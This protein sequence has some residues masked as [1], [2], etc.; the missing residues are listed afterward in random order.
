LNAPL[1]KYLK[2][3]LDRAGF[4]GLSMS[5]TPL[6]TRII[7]N[8]TRPGL[9]IGKGGKTI[10]TITKT[11]EETYKIPNPQIEINEIQNPE[12]DAKAMVDRVVSLL[13]RG[14]SWR[15]VTYKT[16]EDIIRA[17]AQG[18]EVVIKGKLSGKGGR[19][20]KQRIA[21]GYMKKA[22]GQTHL[23]DYAKGNAYP[24]AGAIGVK[25]R[26]IRPNVIFPDKLNI[27]EL[28]EA[29]KQ[30]EKT[31]SEADEKTDTAEETVIVEK[32][33][34][35]ETKTEDKKEEK[36]KKVKD[37]KRNTPK[38]KKRKKTNQRKKKPKTKRKKRRS[39]L[40]EKIRSPRIDKR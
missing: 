26:I 21:K 20:M 30:A 37:K 24:K 3:Q 34:S 8:V 33:K 1:E 39:N 16:V 23:V 32:E 17:G 29:R 22:G 11:I 6:V 2:K 31:E 14:Y 15:S 35:E 12:L 5:K 38:L 10:R 40:N 18:V 27:T 7:L 28:L 36:Q 19:K 25:I 13:E 9:A 4:T